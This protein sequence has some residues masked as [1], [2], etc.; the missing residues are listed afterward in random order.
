MLRIQTHL[1]KQIYRYDFSRYTNI[2]LLDLIQLSDE[3]GNVSIYYKEVVE[4]VGC[5][6]A[7]F[8][9]ALNELEYFGFI[10]YK[11]NNDFKAEI[12]VNI[13]NNNFNKYDYSKANYV[14]INVVFFTERMYAAL[15]AGEIRTFLYLLMRVKKQGYSSNMS[16]EKKNIKSKLFYR[17]NTY[18]TIA[19][20]I[21]ITVR[22]TKVYLKKL[23]KKNI[24]NFASQIDV[25]DKNYDIISI[26]RKILEIASISVSSSKGKRIQQ[27]NYLLHENYIHYVKTICR[28]KKRSN[29]DMYDLEDAAMLMKQ[30][31][32]KA[33]QQNKD[34][35]KIFKNAFEQLGNIFDIKI[36]HNIIKQLVNKDYTADILVY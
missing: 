11:K 7:T 27:K 34:I 3:S 22:M 25:N 32:Q 17:I 20:E 9:N 5:S 21:G 8:Y 33:E 4:K 18:R 16:T 6:Y 31:R 29:L 36:L 28:R 15:S 13:K 2:I 1:I 12:V 26:S 35:Y 14:D 19:R 10:S 30:Y 24:I 23:V